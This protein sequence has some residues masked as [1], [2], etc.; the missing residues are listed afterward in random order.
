MLHRALSN[1]GFQTAALEMALKSSFAVV[2]GE[3]EWVY[4]TP[5]ADEPLVRETRR[6]AAVVLHHLEEAAR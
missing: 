2:R 4:E 6:N 5:I 3:L 1:D